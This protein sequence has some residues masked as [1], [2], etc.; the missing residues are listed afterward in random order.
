MIGLGR[1]ILLAGQLLRLD[2]A[3]SGS[4]ISFHS[5]IWLWVVAV[6]LS[7][8]PP[9]VRHRGVYGAVF[10]LS[11]AR[12]ILSAAYGDSVRFQARLAAILA[13]TTG[14]AGDAEA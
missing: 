2:T 9:I 14:F 13:A 5:R 7:Q 4:S 3:R 12:V 6:R 10:R 11:V 1:S 8:C